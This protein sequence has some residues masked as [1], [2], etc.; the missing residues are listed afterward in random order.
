MVHGK[1][2]E[3]S[4]KSHGD[5]PAIGPQPKHHRAAPSTR[6]LPTPIRTPTL[7]V[8]TEECLP[9]YRQNTFFTTR[10]VHQYTYQRVGPVRGLSVGDFSPRGLSWVILASRTVVD[11]H[12][13]ALTLPWTVGPRVVRRCA[14][15]H[16]GPSVDYPWVILS[17]R[18]LSWVILATRTVVSTHINAL[19][20][21]WT[22]RVILAHDD[23][24]SMRISTRWPFRGLSGDFSPRG[25]YISTHINALALSVDY[26][27]P[28]GLSVGD[29]AH[30]DC[31]RCAYQ[32]V[33]PSVDCRV[34][35]AHDDYPSVCISTR[36]PFRGL[37][38]G[39]IK[40]TRT[41]VG[42]FR[43]EDC[44]RCAYQRVGPSADCRV[45]FAHED[46]RRCAYQR[47]GPSVD[48]RV[49][50]AHDD[51]PSMRISTRWPFRGLSVG[52]IKPTRTV[53]GDFS[54][55]DCRRCA[56]QRVGPS[57]DYPWPTRTVVGDFTPTRTVVGDFRPRG[58]SS[59][60][61][62]TRWPFRGLSGD[63][64][65]RGL[66][67]MRISTR[68]PFRGLSVGDFSPRG[69]SW[70]ILRLR[71][72]SWV[73]LAHEDCRRCAYQRV[74]PSVDCR[75][76]LAHED[77]PSMRISTR[78]PFRGLSVGD[79]SP[80]GL[81]WVILRLRGLSVGDFSPRGLSSMRISTRWPFRGLSVGDFSPRRMS[82]V[83]LR[84]RGLSVGDF[85]PRGL[86][87]MRITTRSPFR[88]LS[89]AFKPTRTV[90]QYTYR[91]VGPSVDCWVILATRTVRR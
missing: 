56:Y 42:D 7:L 62:S 91:R 43:H 77:C 51:Y 85:S 61:I 74:G 38:V 40:P 2:A 70:V 72:L 88:G 73:I 20:L 48:C 47:V 59:M 71:G 54:H 50:L 66:S 44:R 57:V 46:C 69:L 25:Q 9:L 22:I 31:R 39:D 10:T 32:R 23:C 65:P 11:A 80:R 21:P 27:W 5:S 78:W 14:Y 8:G 52:D 36:W 12:I 76:I 18:G 28:R 84:L 41:V 1:V 75:V 60:R 37:S 89:G 26:P 86:S 58:L 81:S 4:R 82:W 45:I 29:F 3:K 30:E 53:V 15:Q 79:F 83:I 33:G 49:I 17:P 68:W 90:H 87:S 64:S 19:A 34:I 16:V 55:E 13:N 6:T 24:P 67:S 63:F 35:L